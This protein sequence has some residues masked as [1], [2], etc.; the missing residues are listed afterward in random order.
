MRLQDMGLV[1]IAIP[2]WFGII[3]MLIVELEEKGLWG[4]VALSFWVMIGAVTSLSLLHV[5]ST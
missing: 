1:L 3:A 5:L 4:I 2:L